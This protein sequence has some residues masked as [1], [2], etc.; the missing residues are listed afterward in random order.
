MNVATA[1]EGSMISVSSVRFGKSRILG[2]ATNRNG[3]RK[4]TPPSL[5][6]SIAVPINVPFEILRAVNMPTATGGVSVEKI[7][8]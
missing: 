8:K 6:H 4:Q 3:T 1:N 7:A 5:K 2:K